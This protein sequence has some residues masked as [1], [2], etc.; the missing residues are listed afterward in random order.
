MRCIAR[1]G[2]SWLALPL[3][4]GTSVVS[5]DSWPGWQGPNRDN[6]SPDT[7]LLK[8]WPASGPPLK[9]KAVGLGGG[10][11]G[12]AVVDGKIYTM[13]QVGAK[14][15]GNNAQPAPRSRA[16]AGRGAAR[17]AQNRGGAAGDCRVVCLDEST[18]KILWA[19]KI[20]AGDPNC[21]PSVDGDR[22]YALDRN[23]ELACL[24]TADGKI[25][26]HKSF[27]RDFHGHMMS[28]W[29]Y[30]ESP[31]ID[32]EKIVCTPGA[33]DGLIVALDK[34][35]GATIWRGR[36]PSNLGENGLDGAGY[37]SIVISHGGGVKQ[38][39]Q[40]VGRGLVSFR[41]EDGKCLWNYNRIAN[42]VA[43]I[44]TPIVKDDY[45]FASTG[46]GAGA[47]LLEL[48]SDGDS[49]AAHEVYF[50]PGNKVQNHHGGMV[51][52]GDYIYMGNGHNNG[53]PLCLDWKT[54]KIAWNGGRG[55]GTGSAA[56]LEADGE[57]YFRYQDGMM[58]LIE[59]TPDGYNL[60]SKFMLPTHNAESWPHPVIVDRCLYLRDQDNLLCYDIARH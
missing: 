29:G 46:Y 9:W 49:V 3:L 48:K 59:A 12:I 58:A 10:Y 45:V 53:F 39:V 23:G 8:K 35:T 32:G 54:G 15:A 11:S 22:V 55:P 21:T 52:V 18:G 24:D 1:L 5:A 33:A 57:L 6:I 56:I 30:S 47:A 25:I 60:R 43:N 16:A 44:P 34:K 13:G 28:G 17:P 31:L 38:Y 27:Q 14:A 2:L 40:I 50:L 20:G 36:A 26:W 37:S 41:A 42:H 4:V 7:G 19:K 51:L